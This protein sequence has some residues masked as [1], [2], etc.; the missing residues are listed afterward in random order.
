MPPVGGRGVDGLRGSTRG[1][2]A[3]AVV[4]AGV[5][6]ALALGG[7]GD[8]AATTK[9][10]FVDHMM[11]TTTVSQ[12]GPDADRWRDIYGCAYD[13]LAKSDL[14]DQLL[15]VQADEPPSAELSAAVSPILADCMAEV[16]ATETTVT[17]ST[18]AETTVVP[19]G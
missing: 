19:T 6:G 8:D 13:A 4:I 3:L 5:L 14:L 2:R 11:E 16:P 7:C 15:E 10:D 1:R 9:D 18:V 17:E 12:E